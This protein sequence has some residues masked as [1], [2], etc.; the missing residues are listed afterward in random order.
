MLACPDR[1]LYIRLAE[2]VEEEELSSLHLPTMAHCI[3]KSFAKC[4]SF[5][6][7]FDT[8]LEASREPNY[9]AL[10]QAHTLLCEYSIVN[11]FQHKE[12]KGYFQKLTRTV[13]ELGGATLASSESYEGE[14]VLRAERSRLVPEFAAGAQ[15][16]LTLYRLKE[17]APLDA[18][19][20]LL[21]TEHLKHL[22]AGSPAGTSSLCRNDSTLCLEAFE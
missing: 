5:G 18:R 3:C 16:P 14:L 21:S 17:D 6:E 8:L 9:E 15:L 13:D 4:A 2:N 10:I 22:K 7:K 1:D 20:V 11:F 19:L 12:L